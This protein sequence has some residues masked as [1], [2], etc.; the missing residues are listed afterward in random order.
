MDCVP[1]KAIVPP[2][3]SGGLESVRERI[4]GGLPRGKRVKTERFSL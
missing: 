3:A 4:F 2:E 1:V